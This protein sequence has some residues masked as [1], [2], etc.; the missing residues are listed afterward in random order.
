MKNKKWLAALLM[1]ALVVG[2]ALRLSQLDRKSLWADELFTLSMAGDHPLWPEPGMRWYERKQVMEID[3][4]DSFLTAKAAEQSPPLNDLLEKIAI[5]WL[6]MTEIAAR[7]PAA[8]ASCALLLWFAWFAWRHPEAPVRRVLTW[9][10]ILLALYPALQVYAQEGRA[11]SLGTSLLG[12]GGLLW[13]LRWRYGFAHWRAPGWGEI[14]LLTLACYTHY[15]AAL[16]VALLL[17]P[18]AWAA[19]R[20]RS[21]VAW[22]R[23][24]TLGAAFGVWLVLNAHAIL[25]TA[26]GKA[27]WITNSQS[28]RVWHTLQDWSY[29]LHGFWL[30]LA[31][32]VAI[33]LSVARRSGRAASPIAW[34]DS[35]M[36]WLT[37]LIVVFLLLASVVV[38]HAGMGH[39]RFYIFAIPWVAVASGMVFAQ[40]Q[41]RWG[42]ALLLAVI[43]TLSWPL[44]RDGRR[45]PKDDFRAIAHEAARLAQ[46][47]TVFLFPTAPNRYMYRIYLERTLKRDPRA[48]MV[49]VSS[50]EDA[51][52]V[53][54]QLSATRHVAV[55]G[56]LWGRALTD[57]V[58][59]QCGHRWPKREQ[60]SFHNTYAEQWEQP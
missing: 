24:L 59:G 17:T 28:E 38:S 18:D 19:T 35:A 50:A 31:M 23:L 56:H 42:M 13:M 43:L 40:V 33:G 41:S 2:A 54:A 47:D 15:N 5:Q 36:V 51:T 39:P 8:I 7:L 27:A 1:L 53:C 30:I 52:A 10:L 14:T 3:D 37:L 16:M 9:T 29:I 32:L 58:Y 22:R 44:L 11:Y 49:A 26:E 25:F 6:G 21:G 34:S 60:K 20:L 57:A 55:Q 12:M 48:H 45:A 46:P 4:L